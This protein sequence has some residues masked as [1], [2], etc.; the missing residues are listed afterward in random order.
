M[1]AALPTEYDR[2]SR[3]DRRSVVR[4]RWRFTLIPILALAI[5]LVA[6]SP[7]AAFGW[8]DYVGVVPIVL[9]IAAVVVF[10]AGAWYD[11]GAKGF[12][13]DLHRANEPVTEADLDL[14]H[15]EQFIMTLCY[16]GVAG[17]YVV[18]ALLIAYV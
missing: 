8:A 3:E 15:R 16:G 14:I 5:L 13:R 6:F 10:F 17:L 18:I 9:T 11:F 4:A 7:L 12:V 1:N 2:Q